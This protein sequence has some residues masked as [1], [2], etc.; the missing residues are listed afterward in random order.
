MRYSD[1]KYE[2]LCFEDVLLQIYG[3]SMRKS[4]G[5][6][7]NTISG[8]INIGRLYVLT[9]L[10][11]EKKERREVVLKSVEIGH[12][13][14]F[15]VYM[16]IMRPTGEH[17]L[18]WYVGRNFVDSKWELGPTTTGNLLLNSRLG[19]KVAREPL[20]YEMPDSTGTEEFTS[21]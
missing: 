20:S 11:V 6:L 3:D 19:T 13:F 2:I 15:P 14:D 9:G 8:T 4:L 18:R 17:R 7:R 12:N 1:G 5:V 16:N 21:F 10:H